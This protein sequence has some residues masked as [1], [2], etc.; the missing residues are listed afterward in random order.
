MGPPLTPGRPGLSRLIRLDPSQRC[1]LTMMIM[2][3]ISTGTKPD[4]DVFPF[5]SVNTLLAMV[6]IRTLRT[7]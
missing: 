4:S 7:G 6:L 2:T 5:R 3:R 1:L